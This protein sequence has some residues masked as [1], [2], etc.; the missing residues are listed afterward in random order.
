[1][2]TYLPN[3]VNPFLYAEGTANAPLVPKL[4]PYGI[5]EV[6]ITLNQTFFIDV[7]TIYIPFLGFDKEG[8]RVTFCNPGA[9]TQ[10][11]K[12]MFVDGAGQSTD[13]DAAYDFFNVV[14]ESQPV[15]TNGVFRV[16]S[17][18]T[19]SGIQRNFFATNKTLLVSM[20]GVFTVAPVQFPWTKP[21]NPSPQNNVNGV[22]NGSLLTFHTQDNFSIYCFDQPQDIRTKLNL[23]PTV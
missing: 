18:G 14:D 6:P 2:P 13:I 10:R 20:R 17:A 3:A 16:M 4:G 5:P 23:L 1:M 12:V 21:N 22:Q 11:K 15:V 19:L 8:W 9:P 7:E